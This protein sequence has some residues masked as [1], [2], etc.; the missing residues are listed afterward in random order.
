MRIQN[1][2]RI[3]SVVYVGGKL[4][5]PDGT[6][7]YARYEKKNVVLIKGI[8]EGRPAPLG[9]LGSV[10][11]LGS[12]PKLEENYICGVGRKH[13]GRPKIAHREFLEL[14]GRWV[15]IQNDKRRRS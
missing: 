9:V 8:L 10:R 13:S 4:G 6:G 14:S 15:M 3:L 1:S 11:R 7:R 5:V 12:D 2:R